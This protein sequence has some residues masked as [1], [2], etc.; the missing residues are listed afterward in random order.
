[1]NKIQITNFSRSPAHGL[2]SFQ[3]FPGLS[4]SEPRIRSMENTNLGARAD[5]M[6]TDQ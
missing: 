3:Q 4:S 5:A 1:M 6:T 2:W